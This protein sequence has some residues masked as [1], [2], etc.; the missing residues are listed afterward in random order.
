[1][2]SGG[3]LPRAVRVGWEVPAGGSAAR[4]AT[5]LRERLAAMGCVEDDADP[6]VLLVWS[7]RT[8]A[9]EDEERLLGQAG[10][11]TPVLL[12]GPTLAHVS[13]DGLLAEAAGLVVEGHTPAHEVRLRAGTAAQPGRAVAGSA[14]RLALGPGS[15]PAAGS[16]G[17][18]GLFR[19]AQPALVRDRVLRVA[20]AADDVEVLLTA[21]VAYTDHPVATYRPATRI[22]TW[23]LASASPDAGRLLALLLRYLAG[24][25]PTRPLGVSLLGFGA[26]GAEHLGAALAVDGLA[27]RAVCDRDPTRLAAARTAAPD[28]L[29]TASVDDLLT[30][31]GTDV[32]VVS[33]PPATHATWAL[34]ALEAGK[35]VVVEKPFALRT[36][37]AAEV[38][39][40]AAAADRLAVVYQ[41]RRYDPDYLALRRLVRSGAIGEVFSLE[42]FVGGY[43]HP[44]NYWHSDEEVSGG[45]IFDWGA[46]V[47]DQVLDL[48]PEPVE[49]VT[50]AE[51]KRVWHDVTNADHSRV[52][53][54]FTG[55][56]EAEFVHSD[57]AAALKPRWYVLGTTGAVVGHWR[58]ERVVARSPVGTLHEDVLAPAD[59]PSRLVLHHPDG[60][61][62]A[63]AT[64]AGEPHP[65]HRELADHLL[66][67]LP[68]SVTGKQSLRVLGVLE[69]ARASAAAGGTPVRPR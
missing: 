41:N 22:G 46:H 8:L 26:I 53:L 19:L 58:A 55:G 16:P 42:T 24:Q 43:A 25:Q 31:E 1:M 50:G 48:L 47:L 2:G 13:A 6:Q 62:A 15:G 20:K 12:A 11:G 36:E 59:S 66:A 3:G 40:A 39:A 49:H 10:A 52:T 65:F 57:L 32:L 30:D 60:S 37:D 45:A 54:R 21:S 7:D 29:V 4:A 64:P 67:G 56:A 34:R 51:H 27:V 5:A 68:M 38:L 63:V 9:E 28:V 35:H 33:T 18:P 23:T 14:D 17:A 44:C 69:A 61:T